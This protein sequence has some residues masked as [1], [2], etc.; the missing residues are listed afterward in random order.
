M[1]H[2]DDGWRR[3]IKDTLRPLRNRVVHGLG[4]TLPER[5][6]TYEQL[7]RLLYPTLPDSLRGEV[8]TAAA[9]D[10]AQVST[11]RRMLGTI[12]HQVAPTA[13]SV[14]LTEE[15]AV[16]TTVGDV[17][18]LC[19]AADA[20]V[21]PGLRSGEYELHLTAV[22]ERY[23]K[24]GMTVVDVGA[25][26]GY[27]SLLASK[28]VGAS[29][30]SSRSSPTRRTAASCCRRCA[31]TGPRTSSWCPWRPTRQRDGPTTRPMS[32]PTEG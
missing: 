13:F 30:A 8:D 26:L 2:R 1:D 21:T 10:L 18:L 24:P 4:G 20:A 17:E 32:A 3:K 5:G 9:G 14:Q 11:I 22:F 23:C 29:G 12:E 19:D 15:D 16:R 7:V 25:N 31:C 6:L 27:Y 28:L